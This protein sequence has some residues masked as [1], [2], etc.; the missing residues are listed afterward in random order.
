MANESDII[1]KDLPGGIV[2]TDKQ[3]SRVDPDAKRHVEDFLK[4]C[5]SRNSNSSSSSSSSSSKDSQYRVGSRLKA[6]RCVPE[7]VAA[8][9]TNPGLDQQGAFPETPSSSSP[10]PAGKHSAIVDYAAGRVS[11]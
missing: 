10:R 3:L 5:V 11:S 8:L 9:G 2:K 1:F 7:L 6:G 4:G